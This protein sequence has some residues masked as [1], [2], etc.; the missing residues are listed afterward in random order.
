[1]MKSWLIILTL[2]SLSFSYSRCG[3][4]DERD[5]RIHR[6]T[7]MKREAAELRK[8]GHHDEAE[9]LTHKALE[10]MKMAQASEASREQSA[11]KELDSLRGKLE[12]LER[13]ALE[14][15]ERNAEGDLKD[16]QA[17]SKQIRHEIEKI[18]SHHRNVQV[19]PQF[20]E[21]AEKLESMARRMRHLQA[22]TEN[23]KAAEMHDMAHEVMKKAEHLEHE[24]GQAKQELARAIRESQ[25]DRNADVA[26]HRSDRDAE[27]DSPLHREL[28]AIRK[29]L[30]E[31]QEEVKRLRSERERR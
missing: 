15:K 13:A 29:E 19:P 12:N 30:R 3:Y 7:A 11:E 9:R 22:A 26:R 28:D 1:M 4:A 6:A 10:M 18:E 14:A 23:L 25:E 21:R 27:R 5:E 16:I 2:A 8:N 24:L 31:S 17:K 20:R